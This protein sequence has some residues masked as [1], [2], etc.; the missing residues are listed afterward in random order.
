MHYLIKR[1]LIVPAVFAIIALPACSGSGS[2]SSPGTNSHTHSGG[3]GGSW[4]GGNSSGG[5]GGS[6]TNP[7][8]GNTGSNTNP[9]GSG[10]SWTT[11]T[12][13]GGYGVIVIDNSVQPLGPVDPPPG[14][15]NAAVPE[16]STLILLGSGL[17][18]VIGWRWRKK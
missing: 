5:N 1:W 17:A 13:S 16:P 11:G 8:G 3:G 14:N 10:G 12:G 7:S 9:S 4:G 6:N 2:G 15:T 18:G